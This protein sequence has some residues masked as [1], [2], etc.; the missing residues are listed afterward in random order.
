[1]AIPR[2]T[3]HVP[4]MLREVLDQIQL[5]PDLIIVD[6]TVG[7]G[8]HSSEILKAMPSS[9]RLIGLDRDAGMLARAGEVLQGENVTLHHASYC[10]LDTV[11]ETL[12]LNQVDRVLLD[13][14]LSSDQLAD[15]GRGF[16]FETTGTLDMRY[17]QRSGAPASELLQ[18]VSSGDLEAIL[19]K[20][21]EERNARRIAREI[22]AR[23]QQGCPV[24]TAAELFHVVN[25]LVGSAGRKQVSSVAA[26]VFQALRIAVNQELEYLQTFLTDVLPRRLRAG[27]RAIVITFHSLEDRLVKQAFREVT[28]WDNLTRKPIVAT[29]QEV[30]LNPRARS[31][32][33]RTAVRTATGP[34]SVHP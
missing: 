1:M 11:L 4:V 25:D 19:S 8:G 22:V 5:G 29:P 26:R 15:S 2:R 7:A 10:E 12:G 34:A 31:A 14:G 18:T 9:C 23:R 13:L 33:L 6:G 28:T 3:V 30:R 17:D 27:G 24:E 16:G 32:K 20:Y 21:A